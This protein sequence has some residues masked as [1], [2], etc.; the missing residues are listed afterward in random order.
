MGG[1]NSNM[2]L[3]FKA[4]LMKM[5]IILKKHTEEIC[6]LIHIMMEESNLPCFNSFDFNEFKAKFGE[7]NTEIEVIFLKCMQLLI[8]KTMDLVE[9]LIQMSLNNWRTTKYDDFQ[10]MSN[11]ILP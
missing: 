3:Y 4:L 8:L 1:I 10:K 9:K 2:F 5:L 7:T 11:G 6:C